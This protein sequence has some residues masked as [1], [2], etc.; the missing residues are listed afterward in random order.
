MTR[1]WQVQNGD[2]NH[3]VHLCWGDEIFVEAPKKCAQNCKPIKN[4]IRETMERIFDTEE[5]RREAHLLEETKWLTIPKLRERTCSFILILIHF[6]LISKVT[7]ATTKY[8]PIKFYKYCRTYS[9]KSSES[10][11]SQTTTVSCFCCQRRDLTWEKKRCSWLWEQRR[12]ESLW[13]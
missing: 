11:E 9:S 12:D 4:Q 3:S 8:K 7:A 6:T 5:K 1:N 13:G 10:F 2:P